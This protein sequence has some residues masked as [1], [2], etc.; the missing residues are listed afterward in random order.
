[1]TRIRTGKKPSPR[2]T[3]AQLVADRA[4]V[5]LTTVRRV[6]RKSP[7]VTEDTCRIVISAAEQL[8]YTPSFVARALSTG[9]VETVAYVEAGHQLGGLPDWADAMER[10]VGFRAAMQERGLAIREEWM[11]RCFL[12]DGAKYGAEAMDRIFASSSAQP[13]AVVCALDALAHGACTSAARWGKSV[14]RDLSVVGYFDADAATYCTPPLTTVRQCG[15][16]LGREVGKTLLRQYL[17]RSQLPQTVALTPNLIIRGSTAP[18]R[19]EAPAA[20]H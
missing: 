8:G 13:T 12:M 19:G 20:V 14:P 6:F 16:D 4:G 3:P 7:L 9:R 11:L 17:D 15:Y 18:P 1:M 2:V 10:E 5:S